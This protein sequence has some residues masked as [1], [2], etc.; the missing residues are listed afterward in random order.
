M[1]DTSQVTH[2]HT[3]Y[4]RHVWTLC[5]VPCR[6]APL[7]PVVPMAPTRVRDTPDLMSEV[8]VLPSEPIKTGHFLAQEVRRTISLPDDCRK[9]CCWTVLT[10]E[11][12]GK[13]P[14]EF[15]PCKDAKLE[16]IDLHYLLA[17]LAL[18]SLMYMCIIKVLWFPGTVFITYSVDV[19]EEIFPFVTFLI[20]QGFRPAVSL[21][22]CTFDPLLD[23]HWTEPLTKAPL[24]L[25][26]SLLAS[27]SFLVS[28]SV[29]LS[30]LVSLSVSLSPG[31]SLSLCV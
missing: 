31:L 27:V 22:T 23:Q 25:F 11:H 28:L 4:K 20:N 24:S 30:L 16:P 6:Q 15:P 7:R 26:L 2:T 18:A 29:S 14:T 5:M 17:T 1:A 13:I 19:A 8:C 3:L 10:S 21:M 12:Y 9:S